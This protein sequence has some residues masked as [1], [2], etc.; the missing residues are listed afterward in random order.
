[1]TNEARK[2]LKIKESGKN[3]RKM[4]WFSG[5]KKA[6]RTRKSGSKNVFYGNLS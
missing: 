1:M 2:S 3:E 5:A 6:K 4:N